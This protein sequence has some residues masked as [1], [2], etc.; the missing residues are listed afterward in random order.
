MKNFALKKETSFITDE[1]TDLDS[2]R[3]QFYIL[4]SSPLLLFFF[5]YCIRD[6][7]RLFGLEYEIIL[8]PLPQ[9]L[10]QS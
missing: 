9:H 7:N 6:L 10:I 2:V 3:Y 1:L 8:R 5:H 4:S